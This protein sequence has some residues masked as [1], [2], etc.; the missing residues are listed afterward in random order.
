[1]D[2]YSNE[3]LNPFDRFLHN[4]S[5]DMLNSAL[6]YVDQN[7]RKPLALYIKFAEISRI[8]ADLDR[9]EVLTACGFDQNGADP[10]AML[11]AMKMAGGGKAT[12]QIDSILNMINLLRTYQTF[13]DFMQN[14]PEMANILT[15]LMSQ[16]G[17]SNPMDLLKQLSPGKDNDNTMNLLQE[18]LKN[19]NFPR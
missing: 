6:P 9:E 5:L 14:N 3:T 16:Q 8:L 19:A 7:V 17:Q 18:L 15:N 12:P 11:R 13:M 2:D 10:E 4:S 1:M